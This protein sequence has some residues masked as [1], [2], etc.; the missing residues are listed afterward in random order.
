MENHDRTYEIHEVAELT[1]L[2][3]A[4]LRAWE[5]RYSAVRP[6]RLPNRYRAY[7]AAQVALLRAFGR[8]IESGARIGDLVDLPQNVVLERAEAIRLD[9]SPLGPLVDALRMLDRMSLQEQVTRLIAEKG[10][11]RFSEEIVLPLAQVVGDLWAVGR[12][13]VAAEH[14][15]S[16]VVVHALKGS[17][18]LSPGVE[19]VL[20][21]ACLPGERHEWGF[22]ATLAQV[23]EQ[24]W[25]VH[26]LGP[27]LPLRDVIDAAWTVRPACVALTATGADNLAKTL[28]ELR[29][30]GSKLPPGTI[31]L[32]GGEGVRPYARHLREAGFRIGQEALPDAVRGEE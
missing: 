11:R 19:P 9:G 21:A 18:Q 23:R 10:L 26:Y 3:P 29:R 24:G 14:M 13:T 2:E 7:S 15:A 30:L 20:L 1:G 5:R 28:T 16:E 8:L 31:M 4:R 25:R 27:D 6:V 32:I 22:L 12:L 17:L